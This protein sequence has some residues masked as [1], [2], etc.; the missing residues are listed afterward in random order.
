MYGGRVIDDYDRRIVNIYMDEYMGDF[1]F[2]A[3][4]EFDF[5]HNENVSYKIPIEAATREEFLF[6]IDSLPLTNTPEV[7]GLHP[8]AEIGY[9]T[10]AV[11]NIWLNLIELQPQT[12]I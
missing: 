12:G 1:L 9:Y 6:A 4:Q 7:Y 5:Y 11:K 3:F 10:Q 8:N 2:D